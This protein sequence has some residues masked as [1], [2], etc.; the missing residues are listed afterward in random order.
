MPV[1]SGVLSVLCIVHGRAVCGLSVRD[2]LVLICSN[3]FFVLAVMLVRMQFRRR[4]VVC[5]CG[6]NVLFLG[7]V[8]LGSRHRELGFDLGHRNGILSQQLVY[9]TS[10][11]GA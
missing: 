11:A 4:I 1:L 9:A 6:L 8:V 3:V 10:A 5:V 7:N 2:M